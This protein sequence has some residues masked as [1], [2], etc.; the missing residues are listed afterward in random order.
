MLS[1]ERGRAVDPSVNMVTAEWNIFQP[2]QWMMP[3]LDQLSDWRGQLA[4]IEKSLH[5][6][7]DQMDV[8]FISDFPGQW[9]HFPSGV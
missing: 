5:T 1:G 4:D 8:V 3:L 6:T 2:T 7:S 9:H